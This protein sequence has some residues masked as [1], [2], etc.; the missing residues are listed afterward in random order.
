MEETRQIR[1]HSRPKESEVSNVEKG[2]SKNGQKWA[3]RATTM[4]NFHEAFV[5]I[6]EVS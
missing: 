1:L 3:H 4:G 2:P 6:S 5:P